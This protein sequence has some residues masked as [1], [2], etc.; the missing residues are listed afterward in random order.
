MGE[1]LKGSRADAGRIEP[2]AGFGGGFRGA[3]GWTAATR[4]AD[5]EAAVPPDGNQPSET[6]VSGI[7]EAEAME[8]SRRCMR[9]DC[10]KSET[11]ELRRVADLLGAGHWRDASR[12]RQRVERIV[13]HERV[14]YEPGK[15]IRCGR[16]ARITERLGEPLGLTFVGRGFGV[17]IAV[18]FGEPIAAALRKTAEQCVAACPTG[19]LACCVEAGPSY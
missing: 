6:Q 5:G 19:A 12:N 17:R 14:I 8:E 15:C 16:C 10:R 1:F 7:S 4:S 3:T 9:C 18:P 13:Q 2:A 11:C